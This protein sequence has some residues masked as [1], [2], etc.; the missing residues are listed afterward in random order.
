MNC[1]VCGTKLEEM[2]DHC[3]CCGEYVVEIIGDSAEAEQVL[4]EKGEKRRNK[5][6]SR[7]EM[8]ITVY[9]WEEEQSK[10]MSAVIAPVPSMYHEAQWLDESFARVPGIDEIELETVI[11]K[12]GEERKVTFTLSSFSTPTFLHIGATVEDGFLLRLLLKNDG[13]EVH[14]SEAV[15]LLEL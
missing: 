10:K 9:K 3:P 4:K 7:Y 12:D 5:L 6:L 13:G 15:S 2:E 1:Y 8:E 14:K 11:K